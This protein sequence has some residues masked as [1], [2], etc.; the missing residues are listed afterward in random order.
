MKSL[1]FLLK[2]IHCQ[3][4]E[5]DINDISPMNDPACKVAKIL[6]FCLIL[7]APDIISFNSGVS[8]SFDYRA[9][10]EKPYW[11]KLISFW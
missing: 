11:P 7:T 9:S 1:W 6:S 5:P 8:D 2:Q 4:L 10:S 3:S